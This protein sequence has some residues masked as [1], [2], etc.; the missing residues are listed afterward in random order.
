[1]RVATLEGLTIGITADRRAEEQAQMFTQRGASVVHG[2][3]IR[4]MPIVD[5]EAARA[6]TETLLDA[7]PSVVIVNTAVG[8]RT[9]LSLADGWGIA[10]D[11]LAAMGSAHVVARGPK[12]AGVLV[13]AG[14][15]VSWRS[16][17]SML[18]EVVDHLLD[19]GVSG[20]RVALQLDGSGDARH[21]I[22]AL[23][24]AG[25]QVVSVP[26]YRWTMPRD[27]VPALRLIDAVCAERMD[28]VTFTAAPAVRNLFTLADQEGLAESLRDAFNGPVLA[29]CVGPVCRAATT[30]WGVVAAREPETARLGTMVKALTDELERRRRVIVVDERDVEVQGSLVRANGTSVLLA[31]RDREL[32][33]V[34]ARRPGVV[35]PRTTML[36]EVWGT[37]H[38]DAHVLEVAVG[39]LRRK[40]AP[41]RLTVEAVLRRG[42]RLA[43]T[44]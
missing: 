43:A 17:S 40:L 25:A 5:T 14:V 16:P 9:W 7:P 32:F 3:S 21:V 41:T 20:A 29:M 26:T 23:E 38:T 4:T 36:A 22:S 35:T 37:R 24:R 18:A 19:H 42:Y 31:G 33:D 2:P 6:A 11:L 30:D 1:V 12:A 28:A 15:D 39:R 44:D 27:P 8:V 13:A 10:D 34:L